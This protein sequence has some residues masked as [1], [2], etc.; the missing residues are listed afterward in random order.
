M[1]LKNSLIDGLPF[2]SLSRLEA[3][4]S[5]V[6]TFAKKNEILYFR[7]V[8]CFSSILRWLCCGFE[9]WEECEWKSCS[10][11]FRW[12]ADCST[13]ACCP[14]VYWQVR[15]HPYTQYRPTSS[16]LFQIKHLITFSF[17]VFRFFLSYLALAI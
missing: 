14:S 17:L 6:Y 9:S 12:C 2:L 3:K 8:A 15:P 1:I 4:F 11:S 5:R 13:A 16:L 10:W 7:H